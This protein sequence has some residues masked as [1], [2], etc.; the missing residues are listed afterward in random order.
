MYHR[1]NKNKNITLESIHVSQSLLSTFI[2]DNL[3]LQLNDKSTFLELMNYSYIY[4]KI[5]GYDFSI[6]ELTYDKMFYEF[7]EIFTYL[8]ITPL[9]A[10]SYDKR[11]KEFIVAN[12][13]C[14][15]FFL[16][17]DKMELLFFETG[18]LNVICSI[19][20][21]QE[22]GGSLIL[23]V[24]NELILTELVYFLTTI[25]HSTVITRPVVLPNNENAVYIICQNYDNTYQ[26]NISDF[27]EKKNSIYSKIPYI[28]IKYMNELNCINRQRIFAF[29]KQIIYLKTN[30]DK[31]E[32]VR[33]KNIF[34][35]IKWCE[36]YYIPH[37]NVKINI[38]KDTI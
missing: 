13:T 33:N 16:H 14:E 3:E 26:E 37:N 6:S 2:S 32:L 23:K 15:H 30:P 9:S 29:K 8:K 12:Y 35:C 22:K 31:L 11:F 1:F 24:T 27:F 19:Y 21:F 20:K 25:Y 28:F 5:P 4:T 34:N 18:Y 7:T 17:S 36:R 10:G 38:F